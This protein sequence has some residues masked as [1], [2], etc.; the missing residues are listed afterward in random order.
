VYRGLLYR[1]ARRLRDFR[2]AH[3]TIISAGYGL[4]GADDPI[5]CYNHEMKGRVAKEWRDL[6]LHQVIGELITIERATH[7]FGFFAGKPEWNASS[8]MYRWFYEAG[9]RRALGDRR[10]ELQAAGTVFNR[11]GRTQSLTGLGL[12]FDMFLDS[13]LSLDALN[14]SLRTAAMPK[15]VKLDYSDLMPR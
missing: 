4:I 12:A 13:D 5:Y 9:V 3:I 2:R 6:D 7:V 11:E 8:A 15:D 1:K 14:R 10:S